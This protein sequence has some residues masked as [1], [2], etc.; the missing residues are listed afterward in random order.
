MTTRSAVGAGAVL[1]VLSRIEETT[2]FSAGISANATWLGLAFAVG[3]L[4][5]GVPAW[6]AACAGALAL[7]AANGAYYA[8]IAVFEPGVALAG[9]AGPPVVWL[10]LGVGGGAVL[11]ATGWLWAV[12]RGPARVL[13]SLPL[14]GVCIAE[15]IFALLGGPLSDGV[16]LVIGVALP[17]ASGRCAA[18]RLL[19]VGLSAGVVAIALTGRLETLMP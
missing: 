6:R 4:A 3:V 10:A 8:W 11:A 15:G 18:E 16:A 9:V 5:R 19:G 17:I 12:S 13:A 1:G 2:G 14:A 7:T